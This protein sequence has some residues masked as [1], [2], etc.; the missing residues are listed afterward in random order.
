M[1]VHVRPKD[2]GCVCLHC[3]PYCLEIGSVAK[4]EACHLVRLVGQQT[5]DLAVS[6]SQCLSYM[7]V[8]PCPA[9]YRGSEDLNLGPYTCRASPLS[10]HP[11]PR[12]FL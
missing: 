10:H 6:S 5:Q 12:Y 9:V 1:C 7:S 8:Q 2:M 11:A 3:L 4:L